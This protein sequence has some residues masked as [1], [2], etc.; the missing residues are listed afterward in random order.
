MILERL[1]RWQH[2]LYRPKTAASSSLSLSL[3]LAFF[4]Q[5]RRR[6]ERDEHE[7]MT[8]RVR[9][10]VIRKSLVNVT[11]THIMIEDIT[12]ND[13]INNIKKKILFTLFHIAIYI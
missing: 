7:Q 9:L 10:Y 2:L 13:S 1:N 4:R 11:A 8:I 6:K 5:R 3:P 12:L